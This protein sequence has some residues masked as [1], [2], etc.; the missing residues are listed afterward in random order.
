MNTERII[1]F[2]D[3][4]IDKDLFKKSRKEILKELEDTSLI[5]GGLRD[6]VE[7]RLLLKHPTYVKELVRNLR[8][9]ETVKAG[10]EPWKAREMIDAELSESSSKS[11]ATINNGK[12]ATDYK[13]IALE[14]LDSKK[15]RY[16]REH[17]A[18]LETYGKCSPMYVGAVKPGGKSKDFYS[19]LSQPIKC[20]SDNPYSKPY[21]HFAGADEDRLQSVN[22]YVVQNP[23]NQSDEEAI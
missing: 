7:A 22:E 21:P 10:V 15:A 11:V 19:E 1:P 23:T 13:E 6:E 16:K 9:A 4:K 20:K 8:I 14:A 5:N 3:G 17:L 18:N 2:N 12:N